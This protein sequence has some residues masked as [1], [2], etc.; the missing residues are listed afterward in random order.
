MIWTTLFLVS[1]LSLPAQQDRTL[2]LVNV[3]STYG[4]LGPTRTDDQL[5]PGDTYTLSFDIDG[6][7][8]DSS[9]KVR[10]SIASE[11]SLAGRGKIFEQAPRE[12]E[13]TI[14]FG[15]NRLPAFAQFN[16][17]LEQ[18]KGDYTV[19][20]TITD[21]ANKQSASFTK[22]AT[23]LPK[24]FGLVK[25]TLTS[26]QDGLLPVPAIGPGQ[27]LWIHYGAVGFVRDN[28]TKQP[29]VVFTL[30]VLDEAGKPTRADK[31][32]STVDKGVPAGLTVLPL[33]SLLS[34]NRPG[35]YNVEIVATDQVANKTAKLV[36]P[37]TV[38]EGK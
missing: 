4:V 2:T 15:G 34:P 32:S 14:S 21:L 9:G 3:R 33:N 19:K 12:T 8:V 29:S 7:A 11:V 10:Y 6:I 26:D 13:T 17:G 18:E 24:D 30:R 1:G 27:P 25:L 5:L 35:Q 28:Q 36:F 22:T 38:V 23:V 16:L 20:I 31:V 37:I